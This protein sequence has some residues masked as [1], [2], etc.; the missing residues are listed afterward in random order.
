MGG[1][2]LGEIN[3][4][5]DLQLLMSEDGFCVQKKRGKKKTSTG[6]QKEIR[7]KV[8]EHLWNSL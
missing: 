3:K 6:S 8:K 5:F 2:I 7:G 4:Q 1:C